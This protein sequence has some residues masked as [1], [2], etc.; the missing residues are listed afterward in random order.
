M[1]RA[2]RHGR[3]RRA[4]GIPVGH[5]HHDGTV[6]RRASGPVGRGLPAHGDRDARDHGAREHVR[7]VQDRLER[8]VGDRAGPR[9]ADPGGEG[10]KPG[11]QWALR[12]GRP[13]GAPHG[14]RVAD[15]AGR[16][17]TREVAKRPGD[18]VRVDD[19]LKSS[20]RPQANPSAARLDAVEVQRLQVDRRGGRPAG[21]CVEGRSTGKDDRIGTR[22]E[23]ECLFER[24]RPVVLH[25][26]V[27]LFTLPACSSR[28]PGRPL[29]RARAGG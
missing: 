16:L 11:E 14:R 21:T 20:H 8:D 22:Q 28:P 25:V 23:R 19:V 4:G 6:H 29:R 7:V 26:H 5:D 1:G 2:P 17:E 18:Q 10:E 12:I 24:E 3:P 9:D 27:R 15:R 13:D